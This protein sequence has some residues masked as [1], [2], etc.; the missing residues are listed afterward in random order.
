[1]L[2]KR[3]YQVL[4]ATIAVIG[5]AAVAWFL[6]KPV[7]GKFFKVKKGNLEVIVNSKGEVKG[8]KFTEINLPAA[9]CNEELRVY[10]LKIMDVIL[11]GKAVRKG[12]YIAKLDDSQFATMMRD[13]MQQ[14]EK[15][16]SDL[17]NE[18]LDSTVVLSNKRQSILNAK[19]DIEYERIDL[20]QWY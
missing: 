10:Q 1:M 11:E 4:L 18:I 14:K 7:S 12:D 16:D 13:V 2:K 20:E 8:D 9:V 19:L 6:F 17:R 3:K 5:I 15:Y